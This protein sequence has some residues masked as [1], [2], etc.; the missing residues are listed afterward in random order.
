MPYQIL[1]RRKPVLRHWLD[2]FRQF[3]DR[4]TRQE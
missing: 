4:R 1:E 3:V 2:I